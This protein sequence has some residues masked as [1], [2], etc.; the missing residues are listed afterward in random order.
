M[1]KKKL[2]LDLNNLPDW[3][4]FNWI[5]FEVDN[6]IEAVKKLHQI[7]KEAFNT[8]CN[9]LESKISILRNENKA[10][11]AD[12]LG[13]YIQHLYGIEEQIIL[14]LNNVQSSSIIIYSFAIFENKLKMISEKVKRDFKFVLPTKKS[15]SY[16]SEYWKVLKSFADLKIN[17]VEKY[18]TPIK[19]QMVLRNIIIHQ[20]NVA[21]KEQYKTIHK[22]PGLTF[23]E[24]EEQYYLV[25]IENIFIDQL[26]G[27]IEIFFREL[28]NIIKLETNERLRNVI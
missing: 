2:Y 18:F 11:N 23:N 6:S 22:V 14:E 17:S 5:D 12:E 28:L 27:R 3:S 13:Q 4:E 7:N 26:V 20:N 9:D 16:T 24:F 19:S 1:T 25:N 10:L 15:D 8:I 21:T